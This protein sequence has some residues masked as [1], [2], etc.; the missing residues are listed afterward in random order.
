RNGPGSVDVIEIDAATHGRVD[1][2]RDLRERAFFSPASSRY[3]IY[4]VD[5]A[6]MVTTEGF[7]ALLKLVEEPPP[8]LK[9]VFATTE[10][11]KVISTIRS[12]THH[13]PFRLVP[14]KVLSDYLARLCAAEDVTLD[15]NALPL[16]VRAGGGSV[17]DSLSI[18][19]Q[20]LAGAGPGGLTYELATS[21][22]GYTPEALLDEVIDALAAGDGATV[23]GVVD[24]VI[25]S[26]QEP[27][28]FTEDLLQRLRDL[29]IASAVPTAFESGL[30]QVP[31]DLAE[32]LQR[33]AS[34]F[35]NADL[36]RCA[37]IVSAGLV[38]FRGATAPRMLLELMCARM[39]LPA[40]DHGTDGLAARLDR[41]ERRLDIQRPAH[42][43]EHT[44]EQIIES[45]PEP[46]GSPVPSQEAVP[47][48]EVGPP[49]VEPSPEVPS[50]AEA[51]PGALHEPVAAEERDEDDQASEVQARE[52]QAS[53]DQPSSVA[54][55]AEPATDEE[56]PP[57]D[58]PE[59]EPAR[60]QSPHEAHA[61]GAGHPQVSDVRQLWPTILEAVSGLRRFTWVMLN[62]NAQVI[63]ISDD[64]ITL[65]LVNAGAR[66]S[67]VR[68]G[69]DEILRQALHQVLGVQ[70]RVETVVDPSAQPGAGPELASA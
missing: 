62:Q 6:H 36:A 59:A 11:N 31:E 25:E 22:L 66:D 54:A 24:K 40:A 5:E 13:Y 26:G 44:S 35:G 3:K 52:V 48:P 37:D 2:A 8:H 49:E 7:N 29:I 27:R 19:D 18:L 43:G 16:V 64:A 33:Q 38:D 42:E 32:R 55:S 28:R 46:S 63:G 60:D 41:L 58:T 21:L 65:G 57:H 70:W 47:P 30:L 9:F 12:R 14:P 4:I 56:P 15:E 17:R 45:S 69:S 61:A 34:T 23:F 50:Q 67:F 68:S 53:V 20:L 51:A 10:P 39:L 1:D